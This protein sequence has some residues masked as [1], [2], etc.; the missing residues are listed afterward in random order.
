MIRE[1]LTELQ[2]RSFRPKIN[3][4]FSENGDSSK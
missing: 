1:I 3:R 4:I 2:A